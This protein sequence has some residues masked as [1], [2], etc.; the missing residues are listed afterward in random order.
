MEL[1]AKHN[2]QPSDNT[3]WAEALQ[4]RS[5]VVLANVVVI[6]VIIVVVIRVLVI[7]VRVLII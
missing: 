5:S 1:G 6:I 2:N 4:I 3:Y 7:F